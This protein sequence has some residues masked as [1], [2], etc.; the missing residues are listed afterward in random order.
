MIKQLFFLL[1]FISSQVCA[2]GYKIN[3]NL[4][5]AANKK[6]SLAYHYLGKIYVQ[7]TTLLDA[8]GSGTWQGDTTL[9]QGLYKVFIDKDNHFDFLLGADQ[10]FSISNTSVKATDMQINGAEETKEFVKYLIFLDELKTQAGDLN[11]QLKETS[12]DKEKEEIRHKLNELTNELHKYWEKVGKKLPDSFLYK[13]LKANYVP[14]LDV[15]SLPAE[16]QNNDSLLFQAKFMYQREHF[17]DNFDYTD[18]RFLYTP[19]YKNKLETWY[20]KVLYPAYDSVKPYVYTF[21]ENVK[22]NQRIFQFATSFFLNS[23]INSK[24]MGMDALFVDLANDFYFTGEAF[25]AS[26]E[27][28]EKIRENVLFKKD[29]LIGKVAPDLTLENFD[30]EFVN[31]HQIESDLTILLIYEPN[32]SHCKVFVPEFYN[33]VYLPNKDKG[34]QVF[35][36]YSMDDKE[37][38]TTFL[39]QHNLFEW[40]NVWDEHHTSRFKITY[41]GRHTP[42]VYVLDKDKKIIAKNMTVKQLGEIVTDKLN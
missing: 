39:T 7:D 1:L 21:I 31:L 32:C 41:D 27:S 17:W 38:W 42:G 6:V 37:E 13:F 10:Q 22:S 2:Q 4:P 18:E 26:E 16:I 5:G 29:N 24:I 14:A 15:T 9:T 35:A 19:F 25:W 30:G 40:L 11:K 28:L 3:V 23:S 36:I 12:N 20:N 33:E 34:L 8:K